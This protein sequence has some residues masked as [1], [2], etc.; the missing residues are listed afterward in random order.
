MKVR[1]KI[2]RSRLSIE[3]PT[4]GLI[5]A[6]YLLWT[7]CLLAGKAMPIAS[8]ILMCVVLTLQSSIVHE[9]IHGHPTNHNALNFCLGILPLT[10]WYPIHLFKET[11]LRHHENIHITIPD[12]DPESYFC[13]FGCWQQKSKLGRFYALANM[14]L[15]GRLLFSVPNTLLEILQRA[16]IDL[17]TGTS[18]QRMHWFIHFCLVILIFV[19]IIRLDSM[20]LAVYIACAAIAHSMISI[21]AFFEHRPAPDPMHRSV[22][23]QSNWF[24]QLLFLNN[25]FHAV[26]HRYPSLPWYRLSSLYKEIQSDVLEKNQRFYFSGYSKWLTFLFRPVHSPIHPGPLTK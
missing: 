5:A 4:L 26:H 21:R 25:N 10:L 13:W 15:V 9:L 16:I 19:L 6:N 20:P 22:I 14:T 1:G 24:F 23:V 12:V 8:A 11:H 18:I 2:P 3:W 17:R 7:A